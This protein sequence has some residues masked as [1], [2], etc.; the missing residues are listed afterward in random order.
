M[1]PSKKT[2]KEAFQRKLGLKVENKMPLFVLPEDL[3]S[4][5]V[6]LVLEVIDGFMELGL[7]VVMFEPKETALAAELAS[8]AKKHSAQMAVLPRSEAQKK[9]LLSVSDVTLLFSEDPTFVNAA[10]KAKSVPVSPL[11]KVV[12]DYNPVAESGN[13]FV[14]SAG[15]KWSLF[16]SCVRAYETYKFPY[17]WNTIVMNA[18][19]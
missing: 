14:Y 8:F 13:G 11:G 6:R 15:K 1:T 4:Q 5:D 3:K 9:Q 7:Q 18:V 2:Q 10:W 16:A 12:V 19:R 17:D